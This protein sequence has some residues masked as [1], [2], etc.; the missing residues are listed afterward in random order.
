GMVQLHRMEMEDGVMRMSE[1][2]GGI[3][4]PAGETVTLERGG[5]HVM[6]M[7]LEGP[8][9][10]GMTVPA[11]LRFEKAGDVEV[12]FNVEPRGG[13]DEGHGDHGGHGGH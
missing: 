9:T 7:Q 12:V 8:L 2:P 5:L 11:T 10:D 4:V 3:P 13:S 1:V 6:F